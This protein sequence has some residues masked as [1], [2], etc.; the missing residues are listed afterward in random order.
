MSE[1]SFEPKSRGKLFVISGP[2]GV[3][4]GT[5]VAKLLE[6]DPDLLLSIS[7]TTRAPRDGEANGEHYFFISKEDFQKMISDD[8]F[9]EWAE[10][11]GNYYGTTRT[12]IEDSLNEGRSIILEI[13][14]QGAKQIKDKIP[15]ANLIFI[16]PP[17]IEELEDRLKGRGSED[18]E[19]IARRLEAANLEL[20]QKME[21]DIAI[22]NDDLFLALEELKAYIDSKRSEE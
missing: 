7:T 20:Q 9:L 3:G 16:E 19:A 17:S 12:F 8:E 13:E 22:V 11:S 6:A 2:S 14:V 5:L 18:P 15:D 4:K 10:Y 21:Y 1:D